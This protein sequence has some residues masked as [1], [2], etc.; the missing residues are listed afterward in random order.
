[1]NVLMSVR[2]AGSFFEED[3][4]QQCHTFYMKDTTNML[5]S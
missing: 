3:A 1:M 4:R 2:Q 5:S